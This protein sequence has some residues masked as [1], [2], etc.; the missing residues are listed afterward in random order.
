MTL[1][2]LAKDIAKSAEAEASAML[3]SAKDDAKAILA[4]AKSKADGIRSEASARTEREATQ[5]AREVVASARQA[6]QKEILVA[7]RKVLDET[8]ESASSELGSPKL[9]GR[10]SLLK[11]LMAKADKIGGNDYSIRPVELDRKALSELAGKRKVGEAIDGLGGFVLESPDG[12]VS[13]DMRFDTLLES[14]WNA[15]LAEINS[16]LFD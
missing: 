4:D 1:E 12:S 5:I 2:T 6:N 10:A 7:R 15:Q 13:Y 14:S 16:I 3:K 11:S 9:S 8:L